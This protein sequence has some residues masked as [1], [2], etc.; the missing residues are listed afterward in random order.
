MDDGRI[1]PWVRGREREL[2][3]TR[4]LTLFERRYECAD[5][6]ERSGDFTVIETNDWVNV[7][8][9]TPGDGAGPGVVL[10]EQFRYGTGEVTLEIPGGVVEPGEDPV[11]AGVRE[12]REE[13][14]YAGDP[15]RVLGRMDANPAMQNNRVTV[16]LVENATLVGEI[17]L[18]DHEQ[19]AARVVP[20]REIP[21]MIAGGEISH[22][23]IIAAFYCCFAALGWPG[24]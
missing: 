2:A 9:L 21:A 10:V 3:R 17:D 22:C 1:T 6:P 12:L 15:A 7:V 14:G 23:I 8:A 24:G 13:T 19:I 5:E 16:L 11:D 4:L 18:D 20:L